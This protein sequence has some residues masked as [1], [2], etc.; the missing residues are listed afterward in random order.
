ML[1]VLWLRYYC[2]MKAVIALQ[3]KTLS[4]QSTTLL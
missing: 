2:T 4:L 1:G 3:R